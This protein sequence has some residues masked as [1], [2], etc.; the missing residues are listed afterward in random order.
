MAGDFLF[1][2]T[3]TQIF[4]KVADEKLSAFRET[5]PNYGPEKIHKDAREGIEFYWNFCR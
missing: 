3:S 2:H 4:E 1:F 5:T